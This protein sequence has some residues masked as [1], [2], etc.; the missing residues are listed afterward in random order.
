MKKQT[1][2]SKKHT[3]TSRSGKKNY[4]FK[5]ALGAGMLYVILATLIIAAGG[6]LLI[7][8]ILP[9][10]STTGEQPV[11]IIDPTLG[12]PKD[13]LQLETFPG[14]TLTPTPSPTPTVEPT[15]SPIPP[16]TPGDNPDRT[17]GG[18]SPQRINRPAPPRNPPDGS[19][20]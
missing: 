19:A 14:A 4:F 5:G 11:I 8:N 10:A 1:A 7:G 13:N 15:A 20:K 6:T 12:E 18:D 3:Y 9:S 17:P 16:R 2:H